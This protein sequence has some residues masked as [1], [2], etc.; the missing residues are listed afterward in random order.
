M[1]WLNYHQLLN[2]WLVA[3]EGSVRQASELLHVTPASVSTQVR[4]LELSL[5]A[6]LLRKQG[7]GVAVTE[8]GEQVA[9]YA[10]DIFA[11]GQELQEMVRGCPAGRQLELRVGVR[12]IMPKFVAF[13]LLQPALELEQPV[14][15]VC[16]EGD[17][18]QLVSDLTIHKLDVV[19]SDIPLDPRYRVQAYSHRLGQSGVVFVATAAL[20]RK[21]RSGFPDSL[22]TAPVLL[23]TPD[24]AVRRQLDR[25]FHDLGF[26]PQVVGEFADSSMMK[27]AGSKG[28]GLLA[29]PSV[30]ESDVKQAYGLTRVG[31]IEGVEE[32]FY[33]VSVERK[34][35]HPGVRAIRQKAS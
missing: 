33:A 31:V 19:L 1:D 30:V 14:R 12:D 29:I 4:N 16:Q 3:R 17:M 11:K 15:L 2:F 9:A 8:V 21:Y 20:A 6:K 32:Q 34:I 24:S 35:T 28:L 10:A 22:K 13:R 5:G 7:R 23:L 18:E 26:G 27:I 25:W